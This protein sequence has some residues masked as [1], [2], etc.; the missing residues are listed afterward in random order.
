[1]E[2][3]KGLPIY[4]Q[5]AK[6]IKE[7]IAIGQLKSG[8]KIP[9]IRDIADIYKVNPNTVQRSLQVLEQDNIIFSKR[10]IGSFVI[11][12]EKLIHSIR[13]ELAREYERIFLE[14]MKKIGIDKKEAFEFLMEDEDE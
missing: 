5:I 4:I 13:G 3:K 2:F 12:D 6:A 14:N 7:K 8:D 9:S 1:M 10:G 11:E